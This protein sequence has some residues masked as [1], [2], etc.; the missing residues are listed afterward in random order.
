MRSLKKYWQAVRSAAVQ[1]ALNAYRVSAAQP[2]SSG[3]RPGL[4]VDVA[5]CRIS[6]PPVRQ[7]QRA[8][9]IPRENAAPLLAANA[10]GKSDESAS[11]NQNSKFNEFFAATVALA[12]DVLFI[13][14][15]P[16]TAPTDLSVAHGVD[17][18]ALARFV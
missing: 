14:V 8:Y 10:R 7:R 12:D 4:R 5:G 6:A 17:R 13:P 11:Q 9:Y 2:D 15:A 3:L 18:R 1:S 16:A